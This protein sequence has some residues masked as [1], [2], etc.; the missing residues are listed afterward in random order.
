MRIPRM[1]FP[2]VTLGKFKFTCYHTN[3]A[4]IT[5]DIPQEIVMHGNRAINCV[6]AFNNTTGSMIGNPTECTG[7]DS[8]AINYNYATVFASKIVVSVVDAGTAAPTY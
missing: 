4:A 5:A 6:V 2:D 1:V 3:V 7:Y 8:Y